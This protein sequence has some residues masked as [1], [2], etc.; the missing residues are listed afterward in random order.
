VSAPL[1]PARGVFETV[2]VASGGPV[3]LAGHLA[4]LR[5]S[6]S[7]LYGVSLEATLDER[8]DEACRRVEAPSRLRI[9]FVPPG[10]LELELVPAPESLLERERHE[11]AATR[12][13]VVGG[14]LGS[15]KWRD[16]R[17]L[18]GDERPPI[19][20]DAGESVLEAGHANVFLAERGRLVTP[21]LDG[22]ILPG[23]TRSRVL[24]LTAAAG[25]ET[26][27]EPVPLARLAR[28][29]EVFLTSSVRGIQ[30][31][32]RC[33]GV[34]TWPSGPLA[35]QLAAALR[36]EWPASRGTR[37]RVTQKALFSSARR[38]RA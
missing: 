20:C 11:P 30:P 6:V 27:E 19:L 8:V 4:R 28:A 18:A 22:R 26:R 14:G 21:P 13:L 34:G 38:R 23:V 15:H 25:I 36:R 24:A 12:L 16:R 31:V 32:G 3:E 29:D 10:S 17:L 37:A 5:S 7:E 33:E 9:A 2:L 1:D 35:A